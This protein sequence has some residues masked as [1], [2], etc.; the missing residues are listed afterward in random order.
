MKSKKTR[1]PP[2]RR[3][4]A[5]PPPYCETPQSVVQQPAAQQQQYVHQQLQQ[6]R[7]QMPE[8]ASSSASSAA[9]S[10]GMQQT[11]HQQQQQQ[12]QQLQV[13]ICRQKI[14]CQKLFFLQKISRGFFLENLQNYLYIYL[15]EVPFIHSFAVLIS[16]K[17]TRFYLDH[18]DVLCSLFVS[19]LVHKC[20]Q[21]G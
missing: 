5:A 20:K 7:Q 15:F 18:A 17:T 12:Q 14:F 11:L 4:T 21:E 10:S 13:E 16:F 9:G 3:P 1:P 19:S 6:Q 2:P 8:T